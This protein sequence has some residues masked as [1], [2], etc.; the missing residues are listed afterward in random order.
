MSDCAW[1][2]S[3]VQTDRHP[4]CAWED[5]APCTGTNDCPSSRRRGIT[6]LHHVLGLDPRSPADGSPPASRAG[7]H[8]SGRGFFRAQHSPT[9][10]PGTGRPAWPLAFPGRRCSGERVSTSPSRNRRTRSSATCAPSTCV[11]ALGPEA[12]E[13]PRGAAK[14]LAWMPWRSCSGSRVV[15]IHGRHRGPHRSFDAGATEPRVW[16]P[17]IDFLKSRQITY[18]FTRRDDAATRAAEWIACPLMDDGSVQAGRQGERNASLWAQ[19][20][21]MA[22]PI[23]CG[24]FIQSCIDLM[25]LLGH[26]GV[27][28]GAHARHRRQ[29][30][31]GALTGAERRTAAA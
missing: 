8:V 19:G 4:P 13:L 10:T 18:L 2:S 31:G 11:W 20:A 6:G 25:M 9:G 14:L 16:S 30:G 17:L 29:R 23:R 26:G 1:C 12:A 7:R 21:R 3:R 15:S 5:R 27:L 24:V 22:H 28:T